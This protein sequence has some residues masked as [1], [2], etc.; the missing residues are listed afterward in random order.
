[1]RRFA[2]LLLVFIS[3]FAFY[4]PV[5]AQTAAPFSVSNLGIAYEYG[6]YIVFQARLILPSPIEE[7]FL[8]FHT[9]GE[10]T[11]RVIPI[12]LDNLGNTSQR[13]D[14]SQGSVR[15]FATVRFQYRVK[16]KTGQQFV[17]EE[18]FFQYEDNRFPWQTLTLDKLT[19]HWYAGD[20]EFGQKAL[21]AAV[22]GTARANKLL[23]VNPAKPINIYIYAS[24]TDLSDALEIGGLSWA[25]GQA[26]PDLHLA[27]V[28]IPPGPEQTVEMERKI[29]H[30]IA[31]ILTYDLLGERYALEPV[32]L[33]EGIASLMELSVNP[34]Y[35]RALL[36]A[37]EKKN[38]MP[39]ADLCKAFPPE[40]G[41]AF[42]AYAQSQSFTNFI[43]ENFGQTGLLALT[44]AYG[45]GL[46]CD[47]GMRRAL[48]QPL[49]Q[50]ESGWRM[51]S[52]G[53]E[54]GLTAFNNLF[55]YLAIIVVLFTVSM[56]NALVFQR[57]Q[58]A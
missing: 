54:A 16:L 24:A 38:L 51:K 6:S 32:W 22:R 48:G 43:I 18:F 58:N 31:H 4:R 11:T 55:P 15:P 10:S 2:L 17:S 33:R 37:S 13:Y 42:L 34:D 53:E 21:D 27:L 35:P 47:Q 46:D 52:L 56:V 40:S 29:P 57:I 20:Q 44:S 28:T 30:E 45:D 50:V 23:L 14:L 39:I 12:L 8:M 5:K 41:R 36:M 26:S 19:V 7:A 25:G 49:S 9:D 3:I 1:M